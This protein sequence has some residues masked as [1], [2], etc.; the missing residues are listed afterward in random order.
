MDTGI[1]SLLQII[2]NSDKDVALSETRANKDYINVSA[3]YDLCAREHFYTLTH[4]NKL[5]SAQYIASN[6][7]VTF[8]IGRSV[9]EHFRKQFLKAIPITRVLGFWADPNPT[10][11][12]VY[13]VYNRELDEVEKL[14]MRFGKETDTLDSFREIDLVDDEFKVKGHPDWVYMDYNNKLTIAELKTISAKQFEDEF[15]KAP[16]YVKPKPEHIL[17]VMPY[18]DR[19]RYMDFIVEN[20]LKINDTAKVFYMCKDWRKRNAKETEFKYDPNYREF[21]VNLNDYAPHVR[22]LFEEAK[23]AIESAKNNILPKRVQCS[24]ID[25]TKA[26]KCPYVA[27]CFSE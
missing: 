9:E 1:I 7:R 11:K 22:A 4:K 8:A 3:L 20:N 12:Y 24:S 16:K 15:S 6:T 25:C 10:T 14:E 19:L 2:K 23:L 26:K 27:R 13:N 18:V 21:S 5:R 17:Q